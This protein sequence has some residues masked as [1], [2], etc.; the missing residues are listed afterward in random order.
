MSA[1]GF[2][3]GKVSALWTLGWDHVSPVGIMNVG[4]EEGRSEMSG[5][6]MG[7]GGKRNAI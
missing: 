2:D 7:M 3:L 1:Q 6:G 4:K 5:V